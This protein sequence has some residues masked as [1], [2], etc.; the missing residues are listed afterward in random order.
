MLVLL[1]LPFWSNAF[2]KEVVIGFEGQFGDGSNIVLNYVVS[3]GWRKASINAYVNSPEFL[4]RVKSD[5][6]LQ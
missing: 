4:Y 1:V 2:L 5:N 3:A 6:L